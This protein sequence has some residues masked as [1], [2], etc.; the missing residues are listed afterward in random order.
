MFNITQQKA[1]KLI[2]ESILSQH[3][4]IKKVSVKWFT[5]FRKI[6]YPTGYQDK[7]A[8]VNINAPGYKNR[9]FIFHWDFNDGSWSMR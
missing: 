6:T 1:T 5:R 4:N 3:P 9:G 2:K 7:I 8:R